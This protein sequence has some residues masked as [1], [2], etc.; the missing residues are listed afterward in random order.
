MTTST[1]RYDREQAF[2]SI[3]GPEPGARPTPLRHALRAL[4]SEPDLFRAPHRAIARL[5]P[6]VDAERRL[7]AENH[8]TGG[9]LDEQW[10]SWTRL[11]DGALIGLSYLVRLCI[12]ARSRSVV[13]PFTLVAVGEY[14]ARRCNP[15]TILEVQYL[16][17]EN[18]ETWE[19]GEQISTFICVGLANLGFEYHGG[20]GTALECARATRCDAGVAARLATA[21]FLSGQYGL[22][23]G[24]V[25]MRRA[26]ATRVLA[27]ADAD[28]AVPGSMPMAMR[29]RDRVDVGRD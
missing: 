23:A 26:L 1:Q 14:G 6:Q 13:A 2:T 21:R 27:V 17:P 16:L 29:L 25:A 10:H 28:G 22:Y 7:L 12:G 19:R 20:V 11:A 4:A 3:G 24:F 15:D 8:K 9:S 5:R 18:L